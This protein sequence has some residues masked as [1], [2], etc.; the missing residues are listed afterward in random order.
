MKLLTIAVALAVL[1]GC[2]TTQ[3]AQIR[4]GMT[5]G[6]VR[7]ALNPVSFAYENVERNG[8]NVVELYAAESYPCPAGSRL[9]Y[10][11]FR[12]GLLSSWTSKPTETKPATFSCKDD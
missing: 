6:E 9:Y 1:P 11:R 4:R 5:A 8:D 12:N 7:L 10:L 3:K 2:M